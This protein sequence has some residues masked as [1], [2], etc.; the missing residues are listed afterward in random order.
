MK[1]HLSVVALIFAAATLSGCYYDPGYSYVRGSGQGGDAYYGDGGGDRYVEPAYDGY[2]GGSYYGGGYY[3]R[4]YYGCCY[5]PGVSVGISNTWY[6]GSGY[7]GEDYRGRRDYGNHAGHWQDRSGDHQRGESHGNG[8]PV[9][10]G[11]DNRGTYGNAADQAPRG[12]SV[13]QH[14][15]NHDRHRDHG[16]QRD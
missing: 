6:G 5:A 16:D 9:S 2:Y 3:G 7:R 13:E 14:G 12:H 15:G 8:R 4:S 10:R 11:N 1:R